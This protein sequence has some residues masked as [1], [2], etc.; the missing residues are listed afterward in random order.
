MHKK[1]ICKALYMHYSASMEQILTEVGARLRARRR[2]IGLTQAELAQSADVS[3]RFLVQLEKG[4]GN[5]SVQRLAEV[6]GALEISLSELF[7]GVGPA[8]P[9]KIALVGLRGAGK[10]TVGRRLAEQMNVPF[11]ELDTLLEEQAGMTLAEIFELRGEGHY[12]T[13]EREVLERLLQEPG[14]AVIAAGGS[15]V[16]ATHSWR[17]LREGA[18]TVWLQASPAS[19]LERVRAQGDLR[20]MQGRP[21]AQQ[22]LEAILSERSSLYAQ[23]DRH[24]DTDELGVD[25]LV[26]ALCHG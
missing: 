12:R 21:N 5:I 15:I 9:L 19:H 16:T 3:P 24:L 2:T 14:G 22:E 23:A 8:R 6:C 1:C 4:Q 13:L 10:S 20:P 7:R 18:H 25:G 26:E 11:M 17:L